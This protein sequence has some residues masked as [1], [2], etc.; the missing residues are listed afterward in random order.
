[1]APKFGSQ[2]KT[3][4]GMTGRAGDI[5]VT[6]D[7]SLELFNGAI[8][9]SSTF[10]DHDA[11]NLFV[12]AEHLNIDGSGFFSAADINVDTPDPTRIGNAGQITVSV[13]DTARLFRALIAGDT[14]TAGSAGNVSLEV[15]RLAGGAQWGGHFE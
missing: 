14:F 12:T 8:I 3:D 2:V 7:G 9:S 13:K 6:V 10:N 4:E 1:M 5:W 11:G 15:G